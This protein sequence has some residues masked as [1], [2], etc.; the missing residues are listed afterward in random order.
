M[1][2][3]YY[4][5]LEHF[6]IFICPTVEPMFIQ[7]FYFSNH[8]F[9]VVVIVAVI[10]VHSRKIFATHLF[11]VSKENLWDQGFFFGLWNIQ[12]KFRGILYN[13]QKCSHRHRWLYHRY[14]SVLLLYVLYYTLYICICFK[15]LFVYCFTFS[16]NF[17]F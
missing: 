6:V 16:N 2:K 1:R 3:I 15:C 9:N 8:Y 17:I 11:Y 4:I 10:V 7:F 14:T 12:N 5:E 13:Q